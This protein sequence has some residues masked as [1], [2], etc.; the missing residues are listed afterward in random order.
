MKDLKNKF[1]GVIKS[2]F[3]DDR[4]PSPEEEAEKLLEG[5]KISDEEYD[6]FVHDVLKEAFFGIGFSRDEFF[7]L[8]IFLQR[9][10]QKI[11][12]KSFSYLLQILNNESN[13]NEEI[14]AQVLHILN[15]ASTFLISKKILQKLETKYPVQIFKAYFLYSTEEGLD[16]L[17]RFVE[18]RERKMDF[19]MAILDHRIEDSSK[20][21]FLK[22]EKILK[23][24][25][26]FMSSAINSEIKQMLLDKALE[27]VK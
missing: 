27:F 20:E 2:P 24:N 8:S 26:N 4:M 11:G 21:E 22:F 23:Q 17:K 7:N 6:S 18:N 12:E 3:Y 1:I 13:F 16:F 9:Y 19:M 10:S 25:S 5:L 14:I 15:N